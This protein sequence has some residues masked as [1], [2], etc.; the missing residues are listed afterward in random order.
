[1]KNNKLEFKVINIEPPDQA[2]SLRGVINTQFTLRSETDVEAVV[3]VRLFFTDESMSFAEIKNESLYS[4]H[5]V[6]QQV[7]A[8]DTPAHLLSELQSDVQMNSLRLFRGN[9]GKKM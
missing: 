6:L 3:S 4:A 8:L 2:N 7:T 9:P 5:R 1:M